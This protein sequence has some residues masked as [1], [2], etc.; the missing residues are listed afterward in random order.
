MISDSNE[1]LN[2]WLGIF[3]GLPSFLVQAAFRQGK[4][5]KSHGAAVHSSGHIPLTT[6]RAHFK[7][8]ILCD[9]WQAAQAKT[10][11]CVSAYS[12]AFWMMLLLVETK[13]LLERRN[14]IR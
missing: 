14:A 9:V 11:D 2:S 7:G 12:G 3:W 13:N 10:I 6:Q 8:D 4:Q 1:V 5:E